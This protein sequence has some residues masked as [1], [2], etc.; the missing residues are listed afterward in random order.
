MLRYGLA[1]VVGEGDPH[2]A[3]RHPVLPREVDG[4]AHPGQQLVGVGDPAHDAGLVVH[5]EESGAARIDGRRVLVHVGP[6][7]HWNLGTNT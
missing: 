3:D 2:V 6:P 7:V 1:L 4:G 5:D